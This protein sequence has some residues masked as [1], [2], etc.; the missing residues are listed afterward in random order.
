MRASEIVKQ[1]MVLTV[2][3]S[4][5]TQLTPGKWKAFCRSHTSLS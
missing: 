3:T 2:I 5:F 4:I 1:H